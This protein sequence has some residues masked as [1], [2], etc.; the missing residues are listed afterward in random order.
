M[1]VSTAQTCFHC[2]DAVSGT[3]YE[4][5]GHVFCCLGCQ[6]VY[7]LLS[8][9]Q[10]QQ[11]Y[12]YDN[13]PGRK[14][15]GVAGR[16]EYLD[17]PAIVGQL[18]DFKDDALT[19][20]TC[21]IPAIHCSA[22]I[23][24]L[25]H[26][27]KLHPAVVSSRCDFM[28]KQAVITFRHGGLSLR[29]LVELLAE[30]GYE[31]SITLQDVIKAGRRF[32][33]RGLV[34]KIAVAG[35]CFGNSMML[36]FP[37]YFGMAAFEA[38][39][40]AFFRWMNLGFALPV[41]L[42][43]GRGYFRSAW[44]SLRQ[45]R[46]NLDVPLALGILVLFMRTAWEV[47][48]AT[49][50]GF[51]DTLC[52]L[53]FFLLVGRWVQQRTYHH[54]SFERDYRSYFPVAVM[55][56][57]ADG[58]HPVPIADIGIGDRLLIRSNEIVP[59]DAILLNGD[60]TID[61]SFVTGESEPVKKAAGEIIYAG[62]RQLE[63]AV[64]V[65]VVKAVSQSHLTR[66]WNNEASKPYE[67]RFRT[68]SNTVS[69][70]F[71]VVLLSIAFLAMGYWLVYGDAAKAWGAF[72]AVLI[73]ACPCA[74][75]L[76]SPFTLSTA[77]S[78]FDKN[79]FYIK[80]T[81]AIEQLA[82]VDCL[83]FDKTGTI[84]SPAASQMRFNGELD[85]GEPAM[86]A[87]VCRNSTHPLS[88]AIVR[89]VDSRE[90]PHVSRFREVSG[91]GVEALVDGRQVCVGSAVFIGAAAS[92]G[93]DRG[94][95][96]YVSIDGAVKGCFSV[97]Q[98]W[99]E[100]LAD[101]L[102]ALAG[103]YQLHLVSGDNDRDQAILR[104]I[105]PEWAGLQ[106]GKLPVEKLEYVHALQQQGH[107]VCMIGDGLNDAGAL[108]QADLG[109]AVS[110]DINSFSP[111]CDAILDGQSFT[112]VPRFLRFAKDTVRV[113]HMS[114]GI[115]L[116]YNL[117]GLGFAVTGMMSPLFAAVLMPMSTVTIIGFTT[118]ATR[119]YAAKN[120]LTTTQS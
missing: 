78:V 106:F 96:A 37:E 46:L 12:R 57:G 48:S 90:L 41:L 113:I 19:V 13:H 99:R 26:L 86:V 25:E 119:V 17:E 18:I 4:T 74:L 92:A 107:A 112:K 117:V 10:M 1:I 62:G 67:R 27:Y 20:F 87:A 79:R 23:W 39:Y 44:Q 50:P 54:L 55:R 82:A 49:G 32:S 104:S 58:A 108:K 31:P 116:A 85:A 84:S 9:N 100:G 38:H 66:L 51:A 98:P 95:T 83:V 70:Y 71:T 81:A 114:F 33:Q 118:L 21:Y 11:Y 22:C 88:R 111:G 97:E 80:N 120:Q 89:W 24:L 6:S 102:H 28:K 14:R 93:G 42:Y 110:D 101:T 45:Q 43:S 63:G 56:L 36:S 35:F 7:R 64:E 53:V 2:G 59:A 75:A 3:A 34:A 103:R 15:M 76:S 8:S 69:R 109:I 73:I 91:K 47:A 94:S 5:D 61:F 77:L 52:G 65:E 68:F 72:T 16:Y 30:V 60:A 105:F 29:A 115:S 40:S